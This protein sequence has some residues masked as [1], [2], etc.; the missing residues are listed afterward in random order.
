MK[1]IYDILREWKKRRGEQFALATLVRVQGSSYRRRGARMLICRDGT[2]IGSLSAGCLEGEVA[3]SAHEVLRTGEPV[4]ISFDTR[5][6]FGCAGKIDIFI[7]RVEQDFFG[8]LA[9]DL[10]ARRV[11]V[12]ITRFEGA[13]F[14][15]EIPPPLQLL[16]VGDGSDNAPFISLAYLLGWNVIEIIDP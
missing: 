6:R 8:N 16:L 11:H 14:V 7:E 15:Q 12:A 3:K 5:R 13:Q 10:A 4:V 9:N 2:T 1:D